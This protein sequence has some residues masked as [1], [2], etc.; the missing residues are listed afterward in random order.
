MLHV[1]WGTEICGTLYITSRHE[2]GSQFGSDF[3]TGNFGEKCLLNID[4]GVDAMKPNRN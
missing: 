3:N 2:F 1:V 4:L